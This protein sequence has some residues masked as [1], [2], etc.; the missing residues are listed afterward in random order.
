MPKLEGTAQSK[1]KDKKEDEFSHLKP[2]LVCEKGLETS[3]S[4][5]QQVSM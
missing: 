3:I 4:L 5:R 2:F 1:Q